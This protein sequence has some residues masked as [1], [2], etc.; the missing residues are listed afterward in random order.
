VSV[1]FF[2]I[3]RKVPEKIK[4]M[5]RRRANLKSEQTFHN[6]MPGSQASRDGVE[7]RNVE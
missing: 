2:L 7:S 4:Q 6:G 5:A 1:V 3:R